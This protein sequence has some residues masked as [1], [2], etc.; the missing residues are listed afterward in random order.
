MSR[1]SE[2]STTF[3]S[4]IMQYMLLSKSQEFCIIYAIPKPTESSNYNPGFCCKREHF[5]PKHRKYHVSIMLLFPSISVLYMA[6]GNW[7]MPSS[8]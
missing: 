3:T 8:M 2:A 6:V 5:Q 1:F 4:W 7:L